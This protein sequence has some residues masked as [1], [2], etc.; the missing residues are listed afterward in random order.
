MDATHQRYAYRCLPLNIANAHGWEILCASGFTASWNG[1]P[2]KD[3]ITLTPDDASVPT[4]SSHFGSG[5]ITFHIPCVFRTEPG[6]DLYVTGPVNQPKDAVAPLTGIVETD[7]AAYS[8][9]MN[10]MFTR[11]DAPVRFEKD[12]PICH[13]F[14][15]RRGA[16]EQIEPRIVAMSQ[17]PEIDRRYRQWSD[18]RL[19]FNS[20]LNVPGSKAVQERWQKMY[21]RGQ[22]PDG[23]EAEADDHRS[24]LRLRNFER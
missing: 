2:G 7:W 19:K 10:W 22:H 4:A 11:S 8:F 13:F 3:A 16:L 17:A 15:V 18:N 23:A 12:E 20:D 14:P 1:T 6:V 24:R 21:F 5:I 9:T